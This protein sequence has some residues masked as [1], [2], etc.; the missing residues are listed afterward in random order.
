MKALFINAS[1]RKNWNTHKLLASA[2]NGARDAG[3]E[4]ELIH[5]Y[6]YS[7]KGCVSC[8]ACKLKGNKTNGLC[9][10]HDDLKPVLEKALESDVLI[11][12]S[13]I[14]Y[15]YPTGMLRSFVERLL[16]PIM[17][18]SRDE[19]GEIKRNTSKKIY[20][21]SIFTMNAPQD[22]AA[23]FNYPAII[24]AHT[25]PFELV[26]GYSETLCVYNTYQFKDY[27][28]YEANLFSEPEKAK[29]RDEHFA[30]D[31]QKAYDLGKRLVDKAR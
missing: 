13:P 18:Y 8:F 14:Y 29:Y 27:S 25:F 19:N 31:L 26:L 20:S 2:M 21:A 16:F 5:L 30:E 24:E 23:K 11:M 12:G 17:T 15:S 4:A 1:P 10:Y 3:A 6:D 7:F 28:R 22:M 9:A